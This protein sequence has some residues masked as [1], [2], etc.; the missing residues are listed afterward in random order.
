[1]KPKAPI[2]L[3][4]LLLVSIAFVLRVAWNERNQSYQKA[5]E[6]MHEATDA[7]PAL[8]HEWPKINRGMTWGGNP[9]NSEICR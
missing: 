7:K 1:M 5:V 4:V 9:T 3:I 6:K 8:P 2:G